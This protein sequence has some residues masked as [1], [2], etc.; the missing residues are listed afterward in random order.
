MLSRPPDFPISCCF[1]V[2]GSDAVPSPAGDPWKLV[3]AAE[4]CTARRQRGGE[5]ETP[6]GVQ[7]GGMLGNPCPR[8]PA[9]LPASRATTGPAVR[10]WPERPGRPS[11]SDAP[12]QPCI[13]QRGKLRWL[14]SFCRP[15]AGCR[16]PPADRRRT[17]DTS[18]TRA[19]EMTSRRG[20]CDAP[21]R[22]RLNVHA[23]ECEE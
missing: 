1:C 13:M 19:E 3:G 18:T 17:A 22:C 2:L 6:A 15:V 11:S 20:C 10:P 4:V 16:L 8:P 14:S 21:V 12:L 23:C 5:S 7:F 9:T